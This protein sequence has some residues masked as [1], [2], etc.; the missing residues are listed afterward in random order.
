M[1]GISPLVCPN[2]MDQLTTFEGALPTGIAVAMFY[3][4]GVSSSALFPICFQDRSLD[5]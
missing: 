4:A 2:D 3:I 5:I 1:P